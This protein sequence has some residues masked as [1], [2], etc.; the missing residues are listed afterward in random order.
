M[1]QPTVDLT[2]I[3]S[4]GSRGKWTMVFENEPEL[5]KFLATMNTARETVSI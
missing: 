5:E 3:H 1:R 4:D 2:I